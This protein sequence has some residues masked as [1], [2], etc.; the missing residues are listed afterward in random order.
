MPFPESGGVQSAMA[1]LIVGFRI[2]FTGTF[3]K[4]KICQSIKQRFFLRFN[5]DLV[6]FF[7]FQPTAFCFSPLFG[8]RCRCLNFGFNI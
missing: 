7:F 5:L 4:G 8:A 3:G 1:V 2:V 6:Q